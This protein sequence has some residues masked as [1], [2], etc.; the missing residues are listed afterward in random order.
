MLNQASSPNH[1]SEFE[2]ALH[3]LVETLTAPVLG[4]P[5]GVKQGYLSR[6]A[7]PWDSGAHFRARDLAQT[8]NLGLSRLG[9]DLALAP[10]AALAAQ[11]G[12]GIYPLPP[13]PAAPDVIRGLSRLARAH[14]DLGEHAVIAIDPRGD[15]GPRVSRGELLLIETAG[16]GVASQAAAVMHAARALHHG[17][18]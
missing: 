13:A 11:V 6:M 17:R 5:L 16:Y 10:L 9:P 14:G 12:C 4:P 7:N 1:P 18:A 8:I 2:W 3:R 15:R